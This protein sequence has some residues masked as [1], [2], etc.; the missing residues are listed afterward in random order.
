LLVDGW[1]ARRKRAFAHPTAACLSKASRAN[2][3]PLLR[4]HWGTLASK[5]VV[6][7]FDLGA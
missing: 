5:K 2:V 3:E 4:R 6:K 1:W 7:E